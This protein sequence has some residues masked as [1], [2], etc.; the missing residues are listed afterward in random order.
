MAQRHRIVSSRRKQM[1]E[2]SLY[3]PRV[4]PQSLLGASGVRLG[5]QLD[6]DEEMGPIHGMCGTL[7]A[8]F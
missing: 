3:S 1:E 4:G 8:D 7:D 6:H 5:G 2:K